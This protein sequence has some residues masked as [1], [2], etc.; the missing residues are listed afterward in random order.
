MQPSQLKLFKTTA[1]TAVTKRYPWVNIRWLVS[2]HS[3]F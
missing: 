2:E 3:Q 1:P